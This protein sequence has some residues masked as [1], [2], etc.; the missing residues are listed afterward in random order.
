[1]AAGLIGEYFGR[2]GIGMVTIRTEGCIDRSP[3]G[4]TSVAIC[5][6]SKSSIIWILL[7]IAVLFP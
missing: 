5:S 6:S 7:A 2:E 1:V 3:D 4:T